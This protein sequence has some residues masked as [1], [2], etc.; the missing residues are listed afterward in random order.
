MEIFDDTFIPP[1]LSDG[2]DHARHC[3]RCVWPYLA[4][5]RYSDAHVWLC[6]SCGSCWRV[7][8]DVLRSV[9]PVTCRGCSNRSKHDCIRQFAVAFPRFTAGA[10]PLDSPN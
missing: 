6:S 8:D 2:P 9:D 1:G 10:L 7:D 4:P 5:V 3:P